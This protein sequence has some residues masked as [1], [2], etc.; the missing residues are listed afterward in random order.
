MYRRIFLEVIELRTRFVVFLRSRRLVLL[1]IVNVCVVVAA[2]AVPTFGIGTLTNGIEGDVPLGVEP[3]VVEPFGYNAGLALDDIVSTVE[4]SPIFDTWDR[5]RGG[6]QLEVAPIEVTCFSA[7]A[8]A[9][10]VVRTQGWARGPVNSFGLRAESVMWSVRAY[11]AGQGAEYM[12]H[13]RDEV[14]D[15]FVDVFPVEGLGTEAIGFRSGKTLTLMWRHGD[16]VSVFGYQ[17]NGRPGSVAALQEAAGKIDAIMK[18]TLAGVCVNASSTYDDD[19]GRSPFVDGFVGYLIPETFPVEPAVMKPP[20]GWKETGGK[21]VEELVLSDMFETLPTPP[22]GGVTAV[23][24][25]PPVARPILVDVPEKPS[26][27]FDVDKAVRDSEG[28]GCGWV[29][30]GQSAPSFD[31]EKADATFETDTRDGREASEMAW[32]KWFTARIAYVDDYDRF[33]KQVNQY[34]SYI[35]TVGHV[36]AMWK[37]ISEAREDYEEA[38]TQYA[39]EVKTR[40][41]FLKE[42]SAARTKYEENQAACQTGLF[43]PLPPPDSGVECPAV[44]DPIV[45]QSAPTVGEKPV[46]PDEKKIVATYRK[47]NLLPSEPD[48]E[49]P[50]LSEETEPP[51]SES[52][53]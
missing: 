34:N 30:T 5:G 49:P 8:P 7:D 31:P 26:A 47:E 13:L 17:I 20:K 11:A 16:V 42:Q 15:C 32:Q 25:P 38:L 44:A 28:P 52:S 6:T 40:D 35:V 29:F 39:A 14:A 10:V 23:T 41:A 33:A 53:P 45:F 4:R 24:L 2:M 43:N 51:E 50:E 1:A 19:H 3:V 18:Q 22:T 48:E 12:H 37:L 27:T 36:A 21:Q 9:P 46:E